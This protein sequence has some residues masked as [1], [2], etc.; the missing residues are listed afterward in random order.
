MFCV[1]SCHPHSG[2]LS[3]SLS[4]PV[5][6]LPF[7]VTLPVML[8]LSLSG[9]LSLIS[10]VSPLPQLSC[11]CPAQGS[12]TAQL[13]RAP[14]S[15][16]LSVSGPLSDS[17]SVLFISYAPS[18]SFFN[19]I[20]SLSGCVHACLLAYMCVCSSSHSPCPH[21]YIHIHI[22]TVSTPLYGLRREQAPPNSE[23]T[24]WLPT[25]QPAGV[26]PGAGALS[27]HLLGSPGILS[28]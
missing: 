17:I 3:A 19:L 4:R 7:L 22:H 9:S 14:F 5:A 27:A 21:T 16:M 11:V 26:Q 8:I 25:G 23:G 24:V 28:P 2:C 15:Q 10:L 6:Y 12:Y 20:F 13:Q 18:F 1:R